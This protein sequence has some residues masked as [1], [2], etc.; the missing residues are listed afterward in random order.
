MKILL[1]ANTDWY[2]Y[3]FRQ[4][5]AQ[6]LCDEGWEVVLVSPPGEYGNRL[7]QKGFRWLPLP[8]STRSA[9][10]LR[11]LATLLK[12]IRLYRRER[13]QVV[14]HFTIK[15]VL[16]G[17]LAAKLVGGIRVV[18]AVTGLGHVFTDHGI[19]AK[20]FRPL[21]R[22]LYRLALGGERVRT[23]FQNA[24]D[25]ETFISWGLVDAARTVLIRGSGVDVGRFAGGGTRGAGRDPVKI[26]F[27][28]RL[29]REK[30]VFELVEAFRAV[31]GKGVNAELLVAG[32][33]YPENPSSLTEGDLTALQ[34]P[35]VTFL[36]HVDDMTALLASVDIVALPSY[37]EGT[38]RILIEAAAMELPIVATDI[39]GCR[40]LVEDGVNGLLVP[41]RSVGPL[42]EALTRL[43]AD[44][45][46]RR[47]MGEAGRQIVIEEFDQQIVIRRTMAVYQDVLDVARSA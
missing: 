31:R 38:P 21:V 28:S 42:A 20:L 30:G 2:L 1:F 46:L 6:R 7:R 14:H 16:Y 19:K 33:V 12:L 24:D 34:G 32:E 15:C 5:L 18:N 8:F 3:N 10:P 29:L 26:L 41:V 4:A 36:G 27:A 17:S 37:R 22:G 13:P 40:G 47:R 11:E 35:G 25:R 45:G 39:A 9:N 23:V 43:A 44:E